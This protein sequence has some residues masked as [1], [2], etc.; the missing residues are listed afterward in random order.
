MQ[1][2]PSIAKRLFCA[3][4]AQ[5]FYATRPA[6]NQTDKIEISAGLTPEMREA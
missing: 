2:K 3:A 4:E 6:F 5:I 1:D